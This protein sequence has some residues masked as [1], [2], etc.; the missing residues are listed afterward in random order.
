MLKT[1]SSISLLSDPLMVCT[2]TKPS[3]FVSSP[4]HR[5]TGSLLYELEIF[6]HNSRSVTTPTDIKPFCNT[7]S[8][9]LTSHFQYN[10]LLK[11][12]PFSIW[13]RLRDSWNRLRKETTATV[14]FVIRHFPNL[15]DSHSLQFEVI[16]IG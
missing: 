3:L 12:S 9:C 1:L 6:S 4:R 7:T 11:S 14:A 5:T 13:S 16:W 2:V 10:S 15:L 8:Q